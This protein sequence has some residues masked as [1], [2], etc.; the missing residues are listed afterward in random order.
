[1]K[2]FRHVRT[3][4][5][6]R[7]RGR[8]KKNHGHWTQMD[9]YRLINLAQDRQAWRNLCS[10]LN[11]SY[12]NSPQGIGKGKNYHNFII[13]ALFTDSISKHSNYHTWL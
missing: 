2:W 6:G 7:K 11:V 9:M 10:S 8:Q 5:G 3:I 4:E 13:T 12:R 1:M